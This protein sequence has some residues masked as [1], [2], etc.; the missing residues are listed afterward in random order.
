MEIDKKIV[1]RLISVLEDLKKSKASEFLGA[2]VTGLPYAQYHSGESSSV[3]GSSVLS[4]TSDSL[5]PFCG[6]EIMLSDSG[7]MGWDAP[8][9]DALFARVRSTPRISKIF[10]MLKTFFSFGHCI[11]GSCDADQIFGLCKFF[12]CL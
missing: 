4:K 10:F 8:W 5:L 9:E 6:E 11:N 2:F 1:K 12:G 3:F 7:G